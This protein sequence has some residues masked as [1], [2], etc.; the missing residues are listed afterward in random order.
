VFDTGLGS[1]AERIWLERIGIV[2]QASGEDL[3]TQMRRS[4]LDP[5]RVSY[6]VLS[7]LHFDHTGDVAAFP[8]ASV[9]TA[10]GEQQEAWNSRG[11]FDFYRAADWERAPR[12]IE[13]DYAAGKPFATFVSHHDLLGDGSV[14]LVDLHGH[15]SGSQGLFLRAPRG[16][17]LLTGD[18]SWVDESWHYAARP[19][20]ADNIE[21]WW[22]QIWRIRKL[23]QLVPSLVVVAGHDLSRLAKEVRDD[24]VLHPTT[25]QASAT[26][27][28]AR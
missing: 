5:A 10:R 22:Q 7:H 1:D 20:W 26:V 23:A 9:V 17:V 2:S 6:V 4:G 14:V 18:A 16:P 25:E 21:A 13:I 28:A 3:A 19:I 27:S 24:V 15:T 12:W 11:L 8:N